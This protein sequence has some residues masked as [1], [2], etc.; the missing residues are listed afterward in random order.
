M[1]RQRKTKLEVV[2]IPLSLNS[3]RLLSAPDT[4]SEK[5]GIVYTGVNLKI[6]EDRDSWLYIETPSGRRGWISREWIQE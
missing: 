1:P 3:A 5:L 2:Q 6:I 4:R